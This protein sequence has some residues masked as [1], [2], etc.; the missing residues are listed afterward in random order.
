MKQWILPGGAG[1]NLL[2]STESSVPEVSGYDVL[3]KFHAASLNFRDLM[4]VEVGP[5]L[6]HESSH[7]NS[8]SRERITGPQGMTSFHGTFF[9]LPFQCHSASAQLKFI[10]SDA[11]GEVITIGDKVTRFQPG[12]RVIPAF[13]QSFLAGTMSLAHNM[14]A[15]G[16]SIDG[17]LREYGSF[18]EQGLVLIPD[19]LSYREA[20]TL[21][22][23]ALT[24][25]DALYGAKPLRPGDSVLVQGTG[26]VSVFALQFARAGGAEVIATTSCAEKE[27][28][29]KSL[30]AKHVINYRTDEQWGQ[31]AKDLSLD[32]RGTDYVI[33]IG[34]PN[35]MA[36]SCLASAI[37]GVIAIVGTR[38]GRGN[39]ET[40]HTNLSTNRRIMVGNRLQLEEMIR[41]IVANGIKPVIDPKVF[42][43]EEV[44]EAFQYLKD[45]NHLG[46]VVVDI[47]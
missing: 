9:P 29:V 47:I 3:V 27:E 8:H 16:G 4:I 31:T 15:L 37:N 33:E 43:F 34:G 25:W 32:K 20:A 17:V 23:A 24:A 45:A 6:E 28:F 40:S 44:K 13:Y 7:P 10:S 35:T 22:C 39:V 30:G 26:G 11:A 5:R 12:Q 46:K 42:K 19:S 41:A 38:G 18:N 21:P 36:Q 14:T 1:I 2:K